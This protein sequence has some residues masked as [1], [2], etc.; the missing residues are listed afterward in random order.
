M[1]K[2][3][4]F[5]DLGS[6]RFI[7]FSC[8]QRRKLL[9]DDVDICIVLDEL[10]MARDKYGFAL[11]AYVVMPSHVH[12]VIYPPEPFLLGRVIGEIKSRSARR[13][14]A[15]WREIGRTR[16]RVNRG[17]VKRTVFWEQRCYDHNCRTIE[18]VRGKIL[19]C[20]NNPV[21]AGLA[22]EHRRWKWSSY[23]LYAGDAGP[24]EIA[25][26]VLM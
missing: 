13:I 21:R 9:T 14:T 6:A 26:L 7:T 8:H 11:L 5:D 4:H 20:H 2:L 17:G 24:V 19:Y 23:A 25:T 16:I 18:A 3:T 22:G 12:L 1:P 15:H 10:Q